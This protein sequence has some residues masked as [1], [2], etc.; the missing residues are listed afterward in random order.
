MT[1]QGL[2]VGLT[3]A[4]ILAFFFVLLVSMR[5]NRQA[6]RL[7]AR[8]GVEA[9]QAAPEEKPLPPGV[10]NR[11]YIIIAVLS[12]AF[13]LLVG[14]NA[15]R[16]PARQ[17]ARQT[18]AIAEYI[19]AGAKLYALNCMSCHGPAGEGHIGPPINN[20]LREGF[21]EGDWNAEK[22]MFEMDEDAYKF[23]RDTIAA[24]RAGNPN[25]TWVRLPSEPGAEHVFASYT[26]MPAWSNLHEGPFTEQQV[27]QVTT[28]LMYGNAKPYDGFR[29][30]WQRVGSYTPRAVTAADG[31]QWPAEVEGLTEAEKAEAEALLDERF[32][33]TA[34]HLF[35]S[36]GGYVGPDLT[37]A[38]TW[39]MDADFLRD[40]V[41]DAP[42]TAHRMPTYF[43][44]YEGPFTDPAEVGA[45][46]LMDELPNTLMPSFK[47]DMT[48]AERDLIVRYLL[49]LK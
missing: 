3:V 13:V 23:I 42:G 7:A 37:K 49:G 5:R 10:Y 41:Y 38:G 18:D 20:R 28:F 6:Q 44:N 32:G 27:D 35:G 30:G 46:P 40:W 47:D 33:C 4:T 11:K 17:K 16:E 43:S 45:S 34:C 22:G 26:N 24:G 19:D 2:I 48:P 15:V 14:F 25:P 36:L 8:G 9:E 39:G 12:W 31:G 21:A 1:A 29:T